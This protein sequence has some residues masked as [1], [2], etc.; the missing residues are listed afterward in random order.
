LC[1]LG[2]AVKKLCGDLLAVY[3]RKYTLCKNGD[4]QSLS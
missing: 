4:F 1:G 3:Q 2:N